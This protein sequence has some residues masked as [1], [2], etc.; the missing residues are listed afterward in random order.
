MNGNRISCYYCAVSIFV[1]F[2]WLLCRWTDQVTK[3]PNIKEQ[4]SCSLW[5]ISTWSDRVHKTWMSGKYR[6]LVSTDSS[7]YWY[8]HNHSCCSWWVRKLAR[9]ARESLCASWFRRLQCV[10]S[11]WAFSVLFYR[12]SYALCG[13]CYGPLSVS[14]CLYARSRYCIKM[15]THRI[16]QTLPH[17]SP[18]T[19][20]FWCQK[21]FLNSNG[22]TPNWGA[23]YR[24]GRVK[25]A[26]F[27]N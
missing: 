21:S 9:A 27:D 14:V 26:N 10:W 23:K 7:N 8:S 24:L 16:L 15:A 5:E 2:Y 4:H 12:M 20:V 11:K 18:E 6:W 22:V 13:I 3:W 25:S 19:L 17:H 1:R